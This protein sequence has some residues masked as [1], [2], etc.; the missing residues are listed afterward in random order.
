[1]E[2]GNDSAKL[3]EKVATFAEALRDKYGDA[4]NALED[5]HLDQAIEQ[6]VRPLVVDRR[7]R[8]FLTTTAFLP[9]RYPGAGEISPLLSVFSSSS[10]P[11]A[12]DCIQHAASAA[13]ACIGQC[14]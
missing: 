13:S 3:Q 2:E 5:G 7:E 8:P 1:M 12:S 11:D 4:S 9:R 6:E 10:L 14:R